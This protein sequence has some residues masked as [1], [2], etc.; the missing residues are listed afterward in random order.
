MAITVYIYITKM[1]YTPNYSHLVG[2]MISKTIG[3][4]GTLFSAKPWTSTCDPLICPKKLQPCSTF[5]AGDSTVESVAAR[6][7]HSGPQEKP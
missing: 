6:E 3:F 1:R 5:L 2:I 7:N 4:R